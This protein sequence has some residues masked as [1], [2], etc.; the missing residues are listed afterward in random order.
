MQFTQQYT[1][2]TVRRRIAAPTSPSTPTS[3]TDPYA[4]DPDK[5]EPKVQG[6]WLYRNVWDPGKRVPG[7]IVKDLL[8]HGS[9][10]EGPGLADEIQGGGQ[11]LGDIWH[12]IK[13]LSP[14]A[15]MS[16]HQQRNAPFWFN[17]LERYKKT[18][19]NAGMSEDDYR[20]ISDMYMAYKQRYVKENGPENRQAITELDKQINTL[21]PNEG[22][23]Y[24]DL[25][26]QRERL[27][28]Q[29]ER[30]NKWEHGNF[31]GANYLPEKLPSARRRTP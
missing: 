3:P 16:R 21:G 27:I 25:M 5:P 24:R 12:G 10:G 26:T 4:G 22:A 19:L 9:A 31:F 13:N 29:F 20:Y 1:R 2:L 6:N 28:K 11:L 15:M 8:W 18:L 30:E 14:A 23:K 17:P 7:K